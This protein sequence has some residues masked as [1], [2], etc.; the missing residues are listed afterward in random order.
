MTAA[1]D[2]RLKTY[3]YLRL[4]MILVI[5]L[6][7][8]A[9]VVEIVSTGDVERSLSDYYYTPARSV[10][11]GTLIAIAA[12]LVIIRGY[13]DV[14]DIFLNLAGM[15]A[16]LVAFVP[17]AAP[18]REDPPGEVPPDVANNVEA[19]FIV[20]GASVLISA[21]IVRRSW[22]ALTPGWKGTR[23]SRVAG[24]AAA[25]VIV[26][27]MWAWYERAPASFA[28]DGSVTAHYV[29]AIVMFVFFAVVVLVNALPGAPGR[30]GAGRL[31][32]MVAYW[33][34]LALMALVSVA[35]WAA[36]AAGWD[37]AVLGVE[38]G[39]IVL[40]AVFWAIQGE[41]LESIDEDEAARAR[42][43]RR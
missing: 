22:P 4:G 10:F 13:D 28:G 2:N 5:V 30:G 24:V 21:W 37:Y 31:R 19:L 6:L 38:A 33:T 23:L 3:R 17:I 14:E 7:G 15:L 12:C 9:V 32:Y 27:G 18:G 8:V 25:A 39:L 40:F 36:L 11:V 35:M 1:S 43:S 34:V 41:E 16:P 42:D 20:G 26:A 29:A